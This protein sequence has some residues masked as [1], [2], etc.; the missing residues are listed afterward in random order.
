MVTMGGDLQPGCLA[1]RLLTEHFKHH[2]AC[3]GNARGVPTLD[4]VISG[5]PTEDGF[6][7]RRDP[8]P[9]SSFK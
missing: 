8:S 3:R 4:T 5:V 2:F 1:D 7:E 9:P 6:Y